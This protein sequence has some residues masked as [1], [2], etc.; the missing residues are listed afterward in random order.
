M[1]SLNRLVTYTN[2]LLSVNN[3]KDYGP[4]GLQVEGK[5]EIHCLISGVSA[6]EALIDAAIEHEADVLLVHH[7]WFWDKE[8]PCII[9]VKKRRLQKL[10]EHDISLLA[11]HLP[12]DAHPVL[13]NNAQLGE[14]FGFSS[15]GVM[16]SQG[17][18]NYGRL[19]EYTSLE[20]FGAK[21]G[22]DLNR[23]PLLISGGDHAIRRV[24]WCSGAAQGWIE[25]A[26][27]LGVDAFISGEISEHTV[28]TARESGIHYISAGHHA[29]ERYGVK[30]LGD[31]LAA[32][33]GLMHTFVDIDNPV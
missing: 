4:N 24:A 33:H 32:K 18:G 2:D 9:G 8:N 28:H 23:E 7:G 13:G 15:E 31:H 19:R 20:A 14:L 25:K 12:L 22:K 3:F 5:H 6:T 11:Y 1:S 30:A 26:I 17:I 10:M 16:D 21:I 27:E 29:T